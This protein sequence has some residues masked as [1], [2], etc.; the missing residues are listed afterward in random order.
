MFFF[1]KTVGIKKVSINEIVEDLGLIKFKGKVE[2]V[3]TSERGTTFVRIS[4]EN[5]SIDVV[6]F[7]GSVKNVN[8]ITTGKFVEVIG[9]VSKYKGKIEVIANKIIVV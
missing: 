6:I 1:N 5:A 2:Y 4:D 9:T 7:K 8:E 3:Y